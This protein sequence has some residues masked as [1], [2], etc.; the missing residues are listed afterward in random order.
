M[1]KLTDRQIKV[2]QA[3]AE[4][5]GAAKDDFIPKYWRNFNQLNSKGM[6]RPLCISG[7]WTWHA[8]TDG[9]AALAS[10][11]EQRGSGG[12]RS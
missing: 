10:I 7:R 2:L 12:Q 11:P 1:A 3:C 6:L 4:D 5:G 8:T 9:R